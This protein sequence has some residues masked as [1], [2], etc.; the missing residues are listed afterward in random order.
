MPVNPVGRESLVAKVTELEYSNTLV[1]FEEGSY[2]FYFM[3]NYGNG[4]K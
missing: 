3:V 4:R 1:L 2:S